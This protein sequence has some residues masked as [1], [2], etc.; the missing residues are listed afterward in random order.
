MFAVLASCEHGRTTNF[1]GKESTSS[2]VPPNCGTRLDFDNI[3]V[4]RIKIGESG[5]VPWSKRIEIER[6][7]L[8]FRQKFPLKKLDDLSQR[9]WGQFHIAGYIAR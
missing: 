2:F 5:Y 9:Q 4:K 3:N 8:S 1:C 6:A 7:L